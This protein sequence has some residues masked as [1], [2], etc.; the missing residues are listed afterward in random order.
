LAALLA[1]EVI[2]VTFII[3]GAL[4][5]FG[6]WLGAVGRIPRVAAPDASPKTDEVIGWQARR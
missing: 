4:G 6:V 3:G 5:L 2:T 1:G